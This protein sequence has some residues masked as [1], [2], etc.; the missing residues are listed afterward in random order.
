MGFSGIWLSMATASFT[1][2]SVGIGADFAIYMIFRVREEMREHGND[3]SKA[4]RFA[5]QTSG[6][7]IFYV[8]SAITVGYAVLMLSGF[9]VWIYLGALTSALIALSAIATLTVLPAALVV[10][11]PKFLHQTPE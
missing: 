11:D 1:A 4:V 2:M 3:I 7:A 10:L 6:R 5:V 9:K 8:S